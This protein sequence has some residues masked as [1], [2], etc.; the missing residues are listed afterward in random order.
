MRFS[1]FCGV[2]LALCLGGAM[3]NV[4]AAQPDAD[5]FARCVRGLRGAAVKAGVSEAGFQRL[6]AGLQ[7]DGSVLESLD[8][9]PEFR[10]P[11]W[12][13]LAGLVDD[14]RVRDGRA[15]QARW[16]DALADFV[17]TGEFDAAKG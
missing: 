5:E 9:Q 7:P 3:N 8:Y 6:T 16:Q 13:Y 12:D 11:I 4:A 2:I 1:S 17:A 10:T 15:M 14:E